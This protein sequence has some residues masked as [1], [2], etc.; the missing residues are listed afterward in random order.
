M[1]GFVRLSDLSAG[2]EKNVE[3]IDERIYAEVLDAM[4]EAL[5][6]GLVNADL[7]MRSAA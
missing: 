3:R 6:S 5:A 7:L 1:F 2:C 4:D